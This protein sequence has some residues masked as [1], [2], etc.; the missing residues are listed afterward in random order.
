M[1]YIDV[2]SLAP[3]GNNVSFNQIEIRTRAPF[4][5]SIE[6]DLNLIGTNTKNLIYNFPGGFHHGRW[7]IGGNAEAVGTSVPRPVTAARARPSPTMAL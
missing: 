4:P 2:A 5:V 6:L 1:P 7:R 3:F